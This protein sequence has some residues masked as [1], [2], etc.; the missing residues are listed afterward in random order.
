MRKSKVIFK[1]HCQV[2]K[3]RSKANAILLR[4][5]LSIEACSYTICTDLLNQ[6]NIGITSKELFVGTDVDYNLFIVNLA[7]NWQSSI[8]A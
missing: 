4:N 6:A 2:V 1:F 7:P 3:I 5:I 8:R